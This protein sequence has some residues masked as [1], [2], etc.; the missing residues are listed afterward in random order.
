MPEGLIF[1]QNE[2]QQNPPQPA[3]KY[4]PPLLATI[5][6][7]LYTIQSHTGQRPTKMTDD[8][9]GHMHSSN[10]HKRS[11]KRLGAATPPHTH[12]SIY[13]KLLPL[14]S[15]CAPVRAPLSRHSINRR[16]NDAN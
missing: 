6:C 3:I 4:H 11:E 5:M 12:V 8:R 9:G 1:L 13:R 7:F 15:G 2:H 10:Q 16:M 14:F